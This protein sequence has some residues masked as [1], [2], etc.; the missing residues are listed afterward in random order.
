V[1]IRASAA[2]N[3]AAAIIVRSGIRSRVAEDRGRLNTPAGGGASHAT[4]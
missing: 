1:P 3:I 4:V 2:A